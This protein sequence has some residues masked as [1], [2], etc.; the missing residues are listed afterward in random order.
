MFPQT[1][2]HCT[3][4]RGRVTV[5]ARTNTLILTDVRA[6]V[7]KMLDLIAILDVKTQQVM[8]KSRI[9]QVKQKLFSGT[10][11]FSGV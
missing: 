9:V 7:D 8:I 3:S 11:Q 5:D 6:N 10:W 4:E 1:W 2:V